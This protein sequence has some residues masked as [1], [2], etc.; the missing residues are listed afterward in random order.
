MKGKDYCKRFAFEITINTILDE[1]AGLVFFLKIKLPLTLSRCKK[2]SSSVLTRQ[3]PSFT[4]AI[5]LLSD[6]KVATGS[7]VRFPNC[8]EANGN[9][10]TGESEFH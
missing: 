8:H 9:L 2:S 10:T 5:L 4:G 1:K 6:N 3:R 7:L